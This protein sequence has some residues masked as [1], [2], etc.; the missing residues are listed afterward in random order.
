[1]A[2]GMCGPTR[3]PKRR[4]QVILDSDETEEP[5][6]FLTNTEARMYAMANGGGRITQV[7]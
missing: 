7:E 4:W 3:A 1:M 2:C 5:H 6:F